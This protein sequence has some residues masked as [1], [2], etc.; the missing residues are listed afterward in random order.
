VNLTFSGEAFN[1]SKSSSEIWRFTVVADM[2][3]EFV[4]IWVGWGVGWVGA[5]TAYGY[6]WKDYF[7]F[8]Y[9]ITN[10]WSKKREY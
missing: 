3:G 7:F 9:L 5:D 10:T 4:K 8:G 6:G 1:L 2:P